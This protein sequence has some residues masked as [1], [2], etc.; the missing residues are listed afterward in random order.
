MNGIPA[1][2]L[3]LTWYT[4]D[5]STVPVSTPL[6]SASPSALASTVHAPEFRERFGHI[7]RGTYYGIVAA[8]RHTLDR[9]NPIHD[10]LK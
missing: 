6:P 3:Y 2:H 4:P 9:V 8:H 7:G 10:S 1:P 5:F